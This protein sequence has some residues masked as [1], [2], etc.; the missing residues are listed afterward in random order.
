MAAQD[1]TAPNAEVNGSVQPHKN[2]DGPT[3]RQR[4]NDARVGTTA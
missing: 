2:A 1:D 4:D 3:M